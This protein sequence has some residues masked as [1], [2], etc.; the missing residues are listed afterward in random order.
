MPYP[1]RSSPYGAIIAYAGTL[2]D[3]SPALWYTPRV[4]GKTRFHIQAMI[5][6]ADARYNLIVTGV[7]D[8]LIALSSDS[9]ALIA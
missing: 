7:G 3:S 4:F 2:A 1:P 6:E 8:S 5:G 9:A